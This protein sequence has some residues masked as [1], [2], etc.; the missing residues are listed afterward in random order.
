MNENSLGN[1]F[2]NAEHE[3]VVRESIL[4][5]VE[6]KQLVNKIVD[7]LQDGYLDEAIE[8]ASTME[9]PL[10]TK[11]GSRIRAPLVYALKSKIE[12]STRG[13]LGG[14]A[15][16]I[17]EARE[18]FELSDSD[19]ESIAT[20]EL[21][22]LLR[23]GFVDQMVNTKEWYLKKVD[24][25][26]NPKI[27]EQVLDSFRA[28]CSYFR[29]ERLKPMI[30]AFGLDEEF[31]GQAEILEDM[32]VGITGS[33]EDYST[34]D[35]GSIL[36]SVFS[37]HLVKKIIH[38]TVVKLLKSY[39]INE[40]YYFCV[41]MR[42]EEDFITNPEMQK[43]I[44]DSFV[45]GLKGNDCAVALEVVDRFDLP[46]KEVDELVLGEMV[47]QLG[48]GHNVK[49]AE[50]RDEF[51]ISGTL[52]DT[53]EFQKMLRN[54]LIKHC[55]NLDEDIAVDVLDEFSLREDMRASVEMQE[56]LIKGIVYALS[57]GNIDDADVLKKLCSG[58]FENQALSGYYD[59][60]DDD[61]ISLAI[62][63]SEEA[64][65]YTA[66][67][68]N[69]VMDF[70]DEALTARSTHQLSQREYEAL[71]G[72][73][74]G[75]MD[76]DGKDKYRLEAA[77]DQFE[78]H[79]HIISDENI[80][81][82]F[83]RGRELFGAEAMIKYS[84]RVDMERHDALHFLPAIESLYKK[85]GMEVK[86]FASQVLM[87]VARDG[88][89]YLEGS[90]HH[91][92]AA[93]CQTIENVDVEQKLSE[94]KKYSSIKKLQNLVEDLEMG[95]GVFASWKML[96]K[97]YDV[98]QLLDRSE[99]LDQLN[100]P[101]MSPKLRNYV[102]SLA[103]HPNISM[104]A[105]LQFWRE[106]ATFLN[107]E[108]EHTDEDINQAKKPS[109]YIS[110]PYLD[111]SAEDLRDAY[112]EGVLDDLQTA[113][114]MERIYSVGVED[115]E[116]PNTVIGLQSAVVKAL[117]KRREKI[118]G[119]AKQPKKLF[120]EL[121][122]FCKEKEILIKDLVDQEKGAVLIE[123][124]T[125]QDRRVLTDIVFDVEVGIEK[126]NEGETYRIRIGKK[127]DPSMAVAGNDTASCMPFGSGKNNVYMFNPNCTQLVLER[128]LP[129]GTWRTAAQS[130][131]TI[132]AKTK[133]PTPDIITGYKEHTSLKDLLDPE[134]F[135]NQ[136]V[137]T[138]D[139][140]EISKNDEGG[141]SKNIKNTYTRFLREY[142]QENAEQ[143]G[144]DRTQVAVGKGYTPEKLGLK[145]EWNT[146]LPLAPMGYSDNVHDECY[147][148]ETGLEQGEKKSLQKIRA[149]KTTDAISAAY[150]EGKAYHDNDSL[151]EYLHK[152]QNNI[153]G[154]EIAN[155]KF[156]RPNLSFLAQE[157]DGVPQAYMIAYEGVLGKEP[158]VYIADLAA[159]PEKK[160][161]APA[162]VRT[163]LRTYFQNY[164][165]EDREFI[166]I[167]TNARERTSYQWI[168]KLAE[169]TAKRN[170]AVVEV[171][172]VS[173]DEVGG[174]IMHNVRI[175]IGRTKEEIEEQKKRY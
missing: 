87:Q 175:Y 82:M 104:A 161:A 64:G 130:I 94:A 80:R 6:S 77:A 120:K 89:T 136:R 137:L 59:M 143:I 21:L 79:E 1:P 98:T 171:E 36:E 41:S 58:D 112:V 20:E 100:D 106:P 158:Q 15:K 114:A 122:V 141:R 65:S 29:H 110:L 12:G 34:Y 131:M 28:T 49:T 43:A 90:A 56:A 76:K 46:K 159:D 53:D 13:I 154:K 162:L 32:S 125:T 148:I 169:I 153:I 126:S 25:M 2:E 78:T 97:F 63:N 167:Y 123:K 74:Q 67:C 81:T 24:L 88:S 17:E 44:K 57:D 3:A 31:L 47:E 128:Q 146:F 39:Y 11:Y 95:S 5:D 23:D 132:D 173:V 116:N 168:I 174:D 101:N 52:L 26:L 149:L 50:L 22:E 156:D 38:K 27:A 86:Q 84:S 109:N 35:I 19:F 163:F 157:A 121:N 166:P 117:G 14:P 37:K 93:V 85:S 92:F 108:D 69:E 102:E 152:I 113:P 142:L 73:D 111:L 124:M 16:I 164:G 91:K 107:I 105:V 60:R 150:I 75:M 160:M 55:N 138:C 4:S 115:E 8:L 71:L 155:A 170:N 72:V 139:N 96:K 134:D 40:A 51:S 172:E 133:K 54:A 147:L 83:K 30:A 140:I 151:M 10:E 68:V 144:V 42:D 135:T 103:F 18:A 145:K 66:L 127:S 61:G 99:I 48:T 7:C 118:K 33:L 70:S 62:R 165:N 129:D 119:L 9:S 45:A